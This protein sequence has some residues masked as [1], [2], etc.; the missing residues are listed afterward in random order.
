MALSSSRDAP[1]PLGRIIQAV[2]GWVERL[3]EVWVEAQV[4]EIKRRNAP[5]QFLTLRDPRAEFSCTATTSARVLDVA[6][7]LPEGS[8]VVARVKPRVHDRSTQLS[9]EVLELHVAGEGRLLAELEQRKRKLQAEGLFDPSRKRRL[10]FLPGCIGVIAGRGSDAE[11][12]VLTNARRRWPAA[13]FRV[14]HA[15]VQGPLAATQVMQ[16]LMLLDCDPE[17]D[18]IV[19]ARGGGALEDLLPFSDEGLVRAVAHA[20][21]PVVSAIGHEA[22]API[23]DLVA[24]VRASTPT[25]A[26]KLVVPDVAQE[27]ALV[28]EARSRIRQAVEQRLTQEQRILDDLRSRPVLR[29]P[30]SAFTAHYDRLALLEHQ[31][32][33]AIDGRLRDESGELAR[34]LAGVRAM[35]PKK[36]LERGYAVLVGNEGTISRVTDATV[37]ARLH[38][39]LF[40][41]EL[42]LNVAGVTERNRDE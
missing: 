21:T 33:S 6:G 28:A 8:S 15:L 31:L 5:T 27:F 11:R 26:A 7:P 10:P 17:V 1:Q 41:G 22:D 13:Q 3:G 25:D 36:I 9:L 34:L 24:D 23:L 39:H 18:V 29:D 42:D 37:G 14:E 4:V 16:A 38:A 40:D 32:R 2:K 30:T 19:I 35:S 20:R 12:D